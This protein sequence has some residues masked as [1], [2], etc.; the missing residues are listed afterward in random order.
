MYLASLDFFIFLRLRCDYPIVQGLHCL[1]CVSSS[2]IGTETGIGLGQ[3]IE[4]TGIMLCF[5]VVVF[6]RSTFRS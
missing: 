5:P 4:I 6:A 2:E 3:G 1:F